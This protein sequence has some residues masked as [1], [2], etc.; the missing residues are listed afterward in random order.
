MMSRKRQPLDQTNNKQIDKLT[1]GLSKYMF[2]VM[3][4]RASPAAQTR[5]KQTHKANIKEAV[6]R[7]V[8]TRVKQ[9]G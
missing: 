4:V 6:S 2:R 5:N 3:S 9:P 1:S 7:K 8:H